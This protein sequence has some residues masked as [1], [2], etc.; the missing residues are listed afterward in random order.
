VVLVNN[1]Q[2]IFDYNEFMT[3]SQP[4]NTVKTPEIQKITKNT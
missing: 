2:Q 3:S 4:Q 1:W